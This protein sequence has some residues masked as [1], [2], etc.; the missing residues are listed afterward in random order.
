MCGIVGFVAANPHKETSKRLQFI[1]QGLFVDSLRG[2]GGTGI[3]CVSKSG[4]ITTH[5]RAL[6]GPDFLTSLVWEFSTKHVEDSRITIGHNRAATIG[7]VKDK[8]CHPFHYKDK[9][10][11]VLV[12]NGTLNSYY[13]LVSK[14][15]RHDVDSAYVAA[16][17]AAVEEEGDVLRK[18]RG[19]FVLVWYN[20]TKNT[21]N[22]ARNSFRDISYM[23]SKEGD[24]YFASEYPMLDWLMS[25]TGIENKWKEYKSPEDD[26]WLEWSFSEDGSIKKPVCRKIKYEEETRSSFRPWDGESRRDSWYD[27]T[28]RSSSYASYASKDELEKLG[29]KYDDQLYVELLTF[30]PFGTGGY[31][32]AWGMVVYSDKKGQDEEPYD[33]SVT[34]IRKEQWDHYY[35]MYGEFFPVRVNGLKQH[36][37]DGKV[38]EVEITA[39]VDRKMLA[40]WEAQPKA[41]SKEDYASQDMVLGPQRL[42]IPIKEWRAKTKQGCANCSNPILEKSFD[43]LKWLTSVEP[44]GVLCHICSNDTQLLLTLDPEVQKKAS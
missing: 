33:I 28:T 22:I 43:K 21:F 44:V 39:S 6:S 30:E 26:T 2:M 41:P 13:H 16:G 24:V 15:F 19:P 18:L 8:N 5:K 27:T 37:K 31:G 1:Q 32:T 34:G 4:E 11:I 42:L 29:F 17:L 36:W 38:D 9:Q 10:E 14:D 7:S 23:M 25:R 3:A 40:V 35:K 20:R 12:H